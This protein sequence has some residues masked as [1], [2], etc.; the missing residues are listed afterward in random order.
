VGEVGGVR[1][2]GG[3]GGGGGVGGW[4]AAYTGQQLSAVRFISQMI[5]TIN[6]YHSKIYLF[7]G[8]KYPISIARRYPPE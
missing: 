4:A 1:G 2:R 5:K 8:F 7:Y 6:A 3:M